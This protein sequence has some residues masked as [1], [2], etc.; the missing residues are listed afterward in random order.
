MAQVRISARGAKRIRRGHLWVY[1]SDIDD[2]ES[3]AAGDIVRVVDQTGNFV[4]Q[5]FYSDRSELTLRFLTTRED[6]IDR[7]WWLARFHAC[8]QRRTAIARE[9]NSYRLIYSEGDLMPSLIVDRYDDVMVMQ[10][11]SQGSDRLKQTFVELL[12]EQFN[13]RA[14]VERNDARVRQF[15]G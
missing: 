11:L 4:G 13:P 15:E 12:L 7:D 6:N 5:A 9:T 1:R 8:A 2:A 3:A 10:T 14:I